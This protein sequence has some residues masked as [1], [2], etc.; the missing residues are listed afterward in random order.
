MCLVI[1][2]PTFGKEQYYGF[3]SKHLRWVKSTNKVSYKQW[4]KTSGHQRTLK[5]LPSHHRLLS[6]DT[7][8]QPDRRQTTA[9]RRWTSKSLP[10]HHQATR[11]STR[12]RIGLKSSLARMTCPWPRSQRSLLELQGS[13]PHVSKMRW[14][15]AHSGTLVSGVCWDRVS[16]KRHLWWSE[17]VA[18]GPDGS[19]RKG[20]ADVSAHPVGQPCQHS[21]P[22]STTQQQQQQQLSDPLHVW[23]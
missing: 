15:C 3:D 18:G 6:V 7:P 19:S 16:K 9:R 22:P 13:W 11:R 1:S 8:D 5:S 2:R 17:S 12:L 20:S 10:P 21:R 23:F 4:W 14:W